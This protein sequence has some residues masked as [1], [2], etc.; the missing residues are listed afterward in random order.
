M[1]N[2]L[3]KF[4]AEIDD[5][6]SRL[7]LD[8][9]KRMG[10]VRV[11]A[12][13]KQELGQIQAFHP[14]R[15]AALISKLVNAR[16][17]VDPLVLIHIWRQIIGA[18]LNIQQKQSF[19]LWAGKNL[20]QALASAKAWVGAINQIEIFE[21][22]EKLFTQMKKNHLMI[23]LLPC[24]A[25]DIWWQDKIEDINIVTRWSYIKSDNNMPLYIL[26]SMIPE[27]SGDDF[28]VFSKNNVLNTKKGF[29]TSGELG[30]DEKFL[31][32]YAALIDK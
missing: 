27:P 28:T 6:D 13:L 7:C 22:A 5:I 10:L 1:M 24:E 9:T 3:E 11:I 32:S 16:L 14:G 23:G 25:N 4:R 12:K 18:S 17:D 29:L 19:G 20:A 21:S 15:E 8:L 30:A 26:A 2:K 31:G